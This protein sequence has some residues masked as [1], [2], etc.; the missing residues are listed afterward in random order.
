MTRMNRLF[1]ATALLALFLAAAATF[2]GDM[3]IKVTGPHGDKT[4]T[5]TTNATSLVHLNWDGLR[6]GGQYD[7]SAYLDAGHVIL[8]EKTMSANNG[9]VNDTAGRTIIPMDK[10]PQ[11]MAIGQTTVTVFRVEQNRVK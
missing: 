6:G 4:A 7:I 11:T 8:V 10:I 2:A 5:L 9:I 1:A 3:T